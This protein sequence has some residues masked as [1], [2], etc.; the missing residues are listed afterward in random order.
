[1]VV[2]AGYEELS[3]TDVW[4]VRALGPT[5][6]VLW[7]QTPV[8]T[9]AGTH[10]ARAVVCGPNGKAYVAGIMRM[11]NGNNLAV[12]CFNSQGG[13]DWSYYY[14]SGD[15]AQAYGIS[16]GAD[17]NLY[18]AGQGSTSA[19]GHDNL[20]LSLT[21]AGGFR[22]AAEND[23]TGN[24]DDRYNAITYGTDGNV[25]AAGYQTGS[26]TGKDIYVQSRTTSGAYRWSDV[27]DATGGADVAKAVSTLPDGNVYVAG[28]VMSA[29]QG[30]DLV[31]VSWTAAGGSRWIGGYNG[32][33]NADDYA[34]AVSGSGSLVYAAGRS[35]E[36]GRGQDFTVVALNTS[37]GQ[38]RWV[39]TI[40][41]GDPT[42]ADEANSLAVTTSGQL[43]VT[44]KLDDP[45][46]HDNILTV[47]LDPFTG[48][49]E[50]RS[51][52]GRKRML[53]VPNPFTGVAR[54]VGQE[55]GEFFVF[56]GAGRPVG[57]C[58]GRDIGRGLPS[59]V[60]FV[61]RAGL[62]ECIRVVKVH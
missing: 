46:E 24:D 19:T 6:S 32:T 16:L 36:T 28:Q 56:N 27:L 40:D 48:V 37:N 55:S 33:D 15:G 12:L 51:P 1:M 49:M 60:Y 20:M 38:V 2:A 18:V 30:A 42:G 58:L 59:G 44:G 14:H 25:Y 57:Q 22:W 21:T 31:V 9:V 50:S 43:V 7:T 3:A 29:T 26:S 54:I 17:G 8:G 35:A 23:G 39:D 5:G 10:A 45:V 4:L 41:G 53:V 61:R 11:G 62:A 34:D 52:V 47:G 13:C